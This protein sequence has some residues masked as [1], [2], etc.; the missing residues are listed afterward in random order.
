MAEHGDLMTALAGA[1][2]ADV[3]G[4]PA[5]VTAMSDLALA[6][7]FQDADIMNAFSNAEFAMELSKADGA[8]EGARRLELRGQPGGRV[9]G[10]VSAQEGKKK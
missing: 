4:E 1:G 7:A 6:G 3:L 8:A 5:F 2:F 10:T 9:R